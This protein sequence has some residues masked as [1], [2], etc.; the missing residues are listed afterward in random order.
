MLRALDVDQ[1]GTCF[2]E[3]SKVW[4]SMHRVL[5][6]SELEYVSAPAGPALGR[7]GELHWEPDTLAAGGTGWLESGVGGTLPR[8]FLFVPLEF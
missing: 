1:Q 5:P 8:F 6:L 7:P 2:G 3:Q 4:D